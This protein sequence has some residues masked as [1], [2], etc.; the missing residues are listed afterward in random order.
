[1]Y[2]Y[3]LKHC[4]KYMGWWYTLELYRRAGQLTPEIIVERDTM[5]TA[6]M[7]CE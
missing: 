5:A 7:W 2:D 3:A 1:M 6:N 4:S